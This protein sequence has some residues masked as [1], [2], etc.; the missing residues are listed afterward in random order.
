MHAC[1][2]A[3]TDT[4]ALRGWSHETT[5]PSQHTLCI[6][7]G[8]LTEDKIDDL[9]DQLDEVWPSY[10]DDKDS[11]NFWAHE[12]NKHGTCAL[13]E[14]HSEHRFFKT[15]LKLHQRYDL[16]VG[17]QLNTHRSTPLVC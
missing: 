15:V 6:T 12:W 13:A 14:F 7:L 17:E 16:M 3:S 9:K 11:D 8:A 10:M 4:H 1:A 5:V 2:H